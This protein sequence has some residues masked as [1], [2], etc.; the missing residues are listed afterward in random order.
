M[1]KTLFTLALIF[2]LS[3]VVVPLLHSRV[4]Q[5][6]HGRDFA[7]GR[8]SIHLNPN[9]IV[10]AGDSGKGWLERPWNYPT[11]V[12]TI[13]DVWI[14]QSDSCLPPEFSAKLKDRLT[15]LNTHPNRPPPQWFELPTQSETALCISSVGP[16]FGKD[17]HWQSQQCFLPKDGTL[18]DFNGRQSIQTELT[19]MIRSVR[20]IKACTPRFD[21]KS[22]N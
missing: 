7:S 10:K 22:L 15:K 19:A 16:S 17:D 1:R 14:H 2:I 18:I 20:I 12:P 11:V 5:L 4:W 13:D 21:D 3:A 9:W 6:V 8:V